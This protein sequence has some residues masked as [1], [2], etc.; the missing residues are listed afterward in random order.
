MSHHRGLLACFIVLTSAFSVLVSGCV[1]TAFDRI[2]LGQSWPENS[3]FVPAGSATRTAFGVVQSGSPLNGDRETMVV[4]VDSAERITGK[5]EVR[6]RSPRAVQSD[7]PRFAL[8]SELDPQASGFA[9]TGP[10]DILRAV[11]DT[12]TN[13]AEVAALRQAQHTIAA[14][15]TRILQRW[16][17][18]VDEGPAYPQLLEA[19]DRVPAGGEARIGVS[20]RGALLFD[21]SVR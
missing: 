7:V 8:R 21:Y 19:L 6:Q 11:A 15:L 12:L 10:L 4:L 14:A 3:R 18:K 1:A 9:Q 16:P 13:S 17:G 5:F 2:Q 20:P